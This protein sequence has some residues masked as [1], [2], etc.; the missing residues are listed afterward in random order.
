MQPLNLSETCSATAVSLSTHQIL[1]QALGIADI[2]SLSFSASSPRFQTQS[3][4][5]VL[6]RHV[7]Q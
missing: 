2:S 1:S 5:N 6:R 7:V 4:Q 3:L